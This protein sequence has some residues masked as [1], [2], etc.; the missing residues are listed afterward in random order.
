MGKLPSFHWCLFELNYF[1]LST[2]IPI[3]FFT[4]TLIQFDNS[5]ILLYHNSS[6]RTKFFLSAQN[7]Y[8]HFLSIFAGF[9]PSDNR[10]YLFQMGSREAS[11]TSHIALSLH[12]EHHQTKNCTINWIASWTWTK[13][14]CRRWQINELKYIS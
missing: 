13:L 2:F 7:P 3:D 6:Q 4:F 11:Q 8:D 14:W 5:F 12:Q 1:L 10:L 9:Y